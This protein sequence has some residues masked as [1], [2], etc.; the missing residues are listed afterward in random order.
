MH[1]ST[2]Q[3]HKD[4]VYCVEA[5]ESE[6]GSSAGGD[7]G[8]LAAEMFQYDLSL[9]AAIICFFFRPSSLIDYSNSLQIEKDDD[10]DEYVTIQKQATRRQK[11]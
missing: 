11:D 7:T 9:I 4:S 3:I 2:I 6:A 5:E 1:T 10:N 8:F